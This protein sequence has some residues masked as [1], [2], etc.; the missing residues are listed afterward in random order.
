[1]AGEGSNSKVGLA[2]ETTPGTAVEPSS[3]IPFTQCS[4][5]APKALLDSATIISGTPAKSKG[6]SSVFAAS[7]TIAQEVDC[8]TV[9][10]LI[11]YANGANGKTTTSDFASAA[12][13]TSAPTGSAGGSGA[14]LPAGAY[15]YRVAAVLVQTLTG[16]KCIMPA[17]SPTASA[18]TVTSG[19]EVTLAFTDPTTLT[20]PT[21]FTY[22]GTA[23]YRTAAGGSNTSMTFVAVQ[24]GTDDGYVDHGTDTYR[25]TKVAYVPATTFYK[26]VFKAAAASAG[27]PR[28][29]SFTTQI[30]KN[31][32]ND[33]VFSGCMVSDM[34]VE[35]G[36]ADQLVNASFNCQALGVAPATGEFSASAPTV[37]KP[38]VGHQCSA[39][40]NDTLSCEVQSFSFTLNNDLSPVYGLCN[41]PFA[42]KLTTNSSRTA[43][44]NVSLTYES[45]D[46]WAKAVND[47]SI[48]LGIKMWGEPMGLASGGSLSEG[49]HGVKAFPFPRMMDIEMESCTISN[50]S[51]P[52]DGPGQIVATMD[53]QADYD[54]GTTTEV[55]ITLINT[56]S[57]YS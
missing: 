10:T 6:A 17:S 30:S 43:S 23:I 52:V 36:G 11:Y 29:K 53:Y 18:I 9:G 13:I 1:M 19:Q 54:S 3:A 8:E 56:T 37:R 45:Q 55:T 39:I 31:V 12:K 26:H 16:L 51:N 22:Y 33:E 4:F 38:I 34:A 7:G 24:S 35:V 57:S 40:I 25:D 47:E 21:G 5:T 15:H 48:S 20:M 28:L 46:L 14:T 41:T 49:L 44:G 50:F 27:Q 42:R 2:T 32:T